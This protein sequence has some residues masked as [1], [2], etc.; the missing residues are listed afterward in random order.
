MA[1]VQT[2]HVIVAANNA[3]DATLTSQLDQTAFM[4]SSEV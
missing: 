3:F 1:V 2:G 4:S